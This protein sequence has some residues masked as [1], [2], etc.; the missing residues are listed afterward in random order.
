VYKNKVV[1]DMRGVHMSSKTIL[2]IFIIVF[3]AVFS[4]ISFPVQAKPVRQWASDRK[5]PGYLEDTFTPFLFADQNRTVHAFTSQWI[6]DGSRRLAVVYRKWS[7]TGGWTRPI[8]VLLAPSGSAT[9]LGAF[10]DVSGTLHVIF[11]Q[12]EN[13]KVDVYYSYARVETADSASAW[14]TPVLIGPGLSGVNSAAM[15]GD[16]Q[17]NLAVIYSGSLDG[18][19]VY[20]VHSTDTGRDWSDPV[21]LFTPKTSDLTPYS[22]RLFFGRE[23]QF[24]AAWNVVSSLGVDEE[25]YFSNYDIESGNWAKPVELEER[26]D[27]PDYFGPSFPAI[28]DNGDEIVIMYNG[29]NPFAGLPVDYGRP[30]QRVTV[31][32]NG[33]Q[34]WS[35]AI[36]PFPFHVGRS[37]EHS[38]ALDGVGRPH[39]LFVQRIETL[40]DGQYSIVGGIWHSVFENG[41]WTN[42]DRFVTTYSPHDVRSIIVQGNVL[43]VVW[44]EDPGEGTHGVWYSY[45]VLDVPELPVV[46]ISTINQP[47]AVT[48]NNIVDV[49]NTPVT[50]I[51]TSTPVKLTDSQREILDG[52]SNPANPIIIG[53]IPVVIVLA[54]VL[55]M[56]R[57]FRVRQ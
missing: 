36:N 56:Y 31:S 16:Q 47:T 19:G 14:S 34:S 45:Y 32:T 5:V 39:A 38:L 52:S 21:Q 18:S 6:D 33:G 23:K 43:L 8:D 22:L 48:S 51:E 20:A 40:V 53:M 11:A 49:N 17:G 29:G 15:S 42:P 10:L 30:V 9:F 2:F 37:G 26:T 41:S 28:V 1:D 25:L 50:L 24:Q 55:L 3:V 7:L 57:Y 46:P 35:E 54:S 44:R 4:A 27:S 13:R 12:G